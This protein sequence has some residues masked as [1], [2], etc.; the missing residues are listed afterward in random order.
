MSCQIKP[1]NYSFEFEICYMLLESV[2]YQNG[3]LL[4]FS[5]LSKGQ[6]HQ[7]QQLLDESVSP[8]RGTE[9]EVAGIISATNNIKT[10]RDS[11]TVMP[12]EDRKQRW[13]E[14]HRDNFLILI[15]W[16][17]ENVTSKYLF[18]SIFF[19]LEGTFAGLQFRICLNDLVYS[20]KRPFS[21]QEVFSMSIMESLFTCSWIKFSTNG[22][23]QP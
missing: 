20:T 18:Y 1:S 3:F 5:W 22:N 19:N 7:A 13:A 17:S 10:V 6:N 4:S 21:G 14:T 9:S 15:N 23:P 16:F 11:S 8:I 12:G 2:I